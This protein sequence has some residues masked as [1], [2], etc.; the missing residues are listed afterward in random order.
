[1]QGGSPYQVIDGVIEAIGPNGRA[2]GVSGPVDPSQSC[3]TLP[4]SERLKRII[5]AIDVGQ[6]RCAPA[7]RPCLP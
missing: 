4:A 1:M 2:L 7:T 6:Q 5:G 3:V